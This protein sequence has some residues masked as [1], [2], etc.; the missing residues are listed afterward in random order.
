MP[1]SDCQHSDDT[2]VQIGR[3]DF[4]MCHRS[5]NTGVPAA[6][7][8]VCFILLAAGCDDTGSF[9]P[10]RFLLA[11]A[12]T[13]TLTSIAIA[14]PD[15]Q[16]S[17]GSNQRMTATA[18]YSDGTKRDISTQAAWR[19]A[20]PAV[21]S[22]ANTNG[23]QVMAKALH[24]GTTTITAS[25]MSRSENIS[26]TVTPATLVSIGVTPANVSLPRGTSRQL[27]ATGV[28]SDNTTQDLTSSVAWKSSNSD[29]APVSDAAR[30]KGHT[31]ALLPGS[32]IVTATYGN[33]SGSGTVS[34]T[35]AALV[36]IEVTPS[37]QSIPNGLSVQFTATGVFTDHSTQDLT[38][39][40]TW[41]SSD[42]SRAAISNASS[43]N[44]VATASS[45]GTAQISASLSTLV[46]SATLNVTNATLTAIAV[47]PAGSSIAQ[48]LTSHFTAIGTYSD[49]STRDLTTSVTW[50][51]SDAAIM[52]ISS[53][54]GFEG[55]GTARHVGSAR[56]SASL[57]TVSGS[58]DA[59]VTNAALVSI[60]VTP[61]NPSVANGLTR[62]F[63]ATG[64]Y[65]DQSTQDLTSVVTWG[66]SDPAVA[67]ISNA[68]HSRGLATAGSVGTATISAALGTVSGTTTLT[69]TAATLVSIAITPDAGPLN[70]GLTRQ[71]NATGTYTDHSTQNLTSAVTWASSS[72]SFASISNV[73]AS[74]GLVTSVSVG[75]TTISATLGGVD[76]SGVSLQVSA[77]S[78]VSILVTPAGNSIAAGTTQQLVG[79]FVYTDNST[80]DATSALTWSTSD[81]SIATI[82]NAVPIGRATGVSPGLVTITASAPGVPAGSTTL[83]VTAATLVSI[84]VAPASSSINAGTQKQFSATGTYTD[85][86]TQNLTTAATWI[87][88]ATPVATISNSVGSKGL[89]TSS[90]VGMT[91]I[92]ASVGAV[93]SPT[94]SLTVTPAA[95][96]AYSVNQAENSVTQ[97]RIDAGGALTALAT[98]RTGAIPAAMAIDPQNRYAYVVNQGDNNISQ[99]TIGTAGNLTP[100]GTVATGVNPIW[101]AVDPSGRYVYAVNFGDSS[102]YL[103]RIAADGTL[104]SNGSFATSEIP[105]AVIADPSGR[106]LYTAD[107]VDDDILEYA[108][109]TGG[110]LTSLGAAVM[111]D[112]P[113]ALA[114]DAT[115]R[116]LYTA[117]FVAGTVSAFSINSTGR[118]NAIGTVAAGGGA[119]SVAV[120]PTGHFVYVV[121]YLDSTVSEFTIGA[122]GALTP[123]GTVST[124]TG[125][126][127]IAVDP[128]GRYAYVTN[129]ADNTL[130]QYTI[131]VDGSLSPAGSVAS[132]S[133]PVQIVTTH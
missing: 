65:T 54:P 79:R 5:A 63:T 94:A 29:I 12:K 120:D 64:L 33:L 109:D 101:C 82:S 43:Q 21:V 85:G 105:Y 68:A 14:P 56:I 45:V 11:Q 31:D 78:V 106:Y 80:T 127:A 46:G 119:N 40:V 38:E 44:G 30:S 42:T 35:Q 60:S 92:T 104:S 129:A 103:Y 99:Y 32:S 59:T 36:S 133:Y 102:T 70:L 4:I 74:R 115:G 18:V 100:N 37:V 3:V 2:A 81:S 114:I 131:N 72:P 15:S 41:T 55:L 8:L 1:D 107:F 73:S 121:N 113:I 108:I 86:T 84:A 24:V 52:A 58:A 91:S 19:V 88:S 123:L 125:P 17:E 25:F 23:T 77:P 117:N 95:V 112:G 16:V 116:S 66:S 10:Q 57:G 51:S 90:G 93:T 97:Y 118:L 27:T 67:T 124:G 83:T 75:T 126:F 9:V 7:I 96:Y 49:H 22:I 53:A 76:S 87:S 62:Q 69:V 28:Y 61:T 110:T 26:L 50:S 89:A 48:G 47:T 34:V 130:S 71:F 20:N 13:T 111:S 39:L 6:L 128:S 122:G 98:V 132:G